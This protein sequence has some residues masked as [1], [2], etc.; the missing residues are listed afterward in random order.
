MTTTKESVREDNLDTRI[1]NILLRHEM[2]ALKDGG[3]QMNVCPKCR[4]DD[5]VHVE[6]CKWE[7]NDAVGDL[8]ALIES[9]KSLS[10]AEGREDKE[11]ADALINELVVALEDMYRQYCDEG[12]SFMSAGERA[13]LVLEKYGYGFDEVGRIDPNYNPFNHD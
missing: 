10:E 13:S 6:G 5:Y 11:S 8:L 7:E 1:A 4:V 3:R 12:H 9:E 2:M